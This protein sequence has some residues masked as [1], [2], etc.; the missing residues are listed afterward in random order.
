MNEEKHWV[1]CWDFGGERFSQKGWEPFPNVKEAIDFYNEKIKMRNF[2][3]NLID[4][5]GLD[6]ERIEKSH[7]VSMTAVF[8]STTL[9]V[10]PS[11]KK[12]EPIND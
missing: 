3:M 10:H 9:D 1:V 5:S 11:F 2:K 4:K 12:K 8:L 6:T 7:T